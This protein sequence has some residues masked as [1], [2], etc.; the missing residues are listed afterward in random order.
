MSEV[1]TKAAEKS[2]RTLTE[3]RIGLAEERRQD[4]VV[5]AEEG[6]TMAQVMDPQYWAHVSAR[7]Q[8]F[9]RI[10]VRL[11]TGEWMAE[12]LVIT[13]G[14]NWAQVHML[15][16]HE[17]VERTEVMPVAAKHQVVWKGPQRK[18]VV[19]RLSDQQPVQEGFSTKNE[20]QAWVT[21]HEKAA[22]R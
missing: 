9:D 20:A 4:W 12:L 21:E 1:A 8:P 2:A 17:L 15:A 16:L 3:A 13:T 22:E 10:D 18:H 6:T 11:E 7:M 14:R 19:V 5:N